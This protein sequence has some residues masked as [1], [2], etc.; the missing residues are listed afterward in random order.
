VDLA[1]IVLF[2][3][4]RVD[5]LTQTIAALKNNY[6]AFDSDLIIF[7]DGAKNERDALAVEEVRRVLKNVNGFKSVTVNKSPVN[8]GL[9]KSIIN[10]VTTVLKTYESVI[11]LEDDL[12]SSSNFLDFMNQGLEFYKY[13]SEIFSV[14]GFSIPIVSNSDYDNYFTFRSSSHGW[15]TWK[16]RW[17]L[18]DWNVSDYIEF[19]KNHIRRVLF[20]KMGSDMCA[21]LDK[22]MKGRLDSWAIRWCYYQSKYQLYSVHPFVSKI[23]NIGFSEEASNTKDKFNRFKT[24]LDNGTKRKFLFSNSL[25]T[26]REVIR[27]F[28]R[29][30]SLY[31][32]FYYKI[33][34]LIS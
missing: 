33:L 15:G 22:Q 24:F 14:G 18:I 2:T 29:P 6:L 13:N 4:K 31:M 25:N 20:N 8:L 9:A 32:R 10:G 26:D 30:Y 12:V 17:D 19:K 3:Y 1:P 34:A 21:M 28:V 5:T 7:S 27:Q 11:V 16:D 23:E